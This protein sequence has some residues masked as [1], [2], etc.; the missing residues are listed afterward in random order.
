VA[1]PDRGERVSVDYEAAA[2]EEARIRGARANR[3]G[4][5]VLALVMIPG[6][7]LLFALYRVGEG[8]R[9]VGLLRRGRATRARLVDRRPGSDEID[10]QSE[11]RMRLVFR[12][13]DGVERSFE[14][15]T[16]SPER[17]EDDATELAVYDPRQPA[18]ATTIDHL[19]GKLE[20]RD[21]RVVPHQRLWHL[22]LL[23]ALGLVALAAMVVAPRVF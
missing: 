11:A 20:L 8:A 17:L 1:P 22:F 4:P 5:W 3:F 23:P 7:G 10:E 9:T 13:D 14:V 12:D 6:F 19:P 18:H 15:R 2:P 21:D 16:F